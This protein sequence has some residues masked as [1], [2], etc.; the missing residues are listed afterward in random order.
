L[1]AISA[2][3]SSHGDPVFGDAQKQSLRIGAVQQFDEFRIADRD[4]GVRPQRSLHPHAVPFIVLLLP[5]G[6][7]VRS[8]DAALQ[9]FGMT[10]RTSMPRARTRSASV[11]AWRRPSMSS[12]TRW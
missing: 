4:V 2:I 9:R 12:S 10:Q 5:N 8:H 6:S 11:A 3:G 7:E 1:D